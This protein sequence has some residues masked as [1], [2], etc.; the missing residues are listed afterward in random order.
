MTSCAVERA[1]RSLGIPKY[2]LAEQQDEP[3]LPDRDSYVRYRLNN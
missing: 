3:G 1:S 2:A